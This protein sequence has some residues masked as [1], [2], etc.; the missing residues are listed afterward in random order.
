[1]A[2]ALEFTTVPKERPADGATPEEAGFVPIKVDGV[3]YF[4]KRP[5][6]AVAAQ[7]G[8]ATSRRTNPLLKTSLVLDFLEDCI[9]E[10]GRTQLR[11]RLL[12]ENDDFDVPDALAVLHGIA[13]Y[14][15]AH[16]EL[17]KR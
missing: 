1:M 9:A 17:V 15:K 2:D 7:L 6:D 10:P 3:E 12:D 4:C 8:P 11:N 16:P 13:D 14:W 5:K